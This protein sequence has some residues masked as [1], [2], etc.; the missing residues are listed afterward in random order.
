MCG[1]SIATLGF[2][3]SSFATCV[4]HLFVTFSLMIGL[5]LG[6]IFVPAVEAIN[7]YFDIKKN[8]AFG[9]SLS[10][11]GCGMLVYPLLNK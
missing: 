11:V 2:G 4:E 5:G 10:G 1:A 8:I 9:L 3:L 6:I 7:A